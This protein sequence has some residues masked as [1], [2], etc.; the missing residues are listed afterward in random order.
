VYSNARVGLLCLLAPHMDWPEMVL[1]RSDELLVQAR[2]G[3]R[4][5]SFTVLD[6]GDVSRTHQEAQRQ[7]ADLV[8]RGAEVLVLYISGWVYGSTVVAAAQAAGVPVVL[9]TNAQKGTGGLIGAGVARGSLDEVGIEAP[10]VYGNFEDVR[11][12]HELRVHCLGRAAAQRLR[13]QTFGLMGGRTYGMYTAAIDPSHWRKRFGIEVENFDQLEVIERARAIPEGEARRYLAWVKSEF[14]GVH[15]ADEVMLRQ[16]RLYLAMKQVIA[17]LGLDFATVR[18]L[19]ET[20]SVY[21]TF[22][23][24]HALLNDTS[25]ADGLKA[26]FVCACENDANAALT[27]QLMKH[28]SGETACF[29]DMRHLDMATR[30]LTIANCGSQPTDLAA[31]RR[32]VHWMPDAFG[33]RHFQVGGACAQYVCKPGQ[34]TLGRLSRIDGQYVMLLARGEALERG[35]E[36]LE[37]GTSFSCTAQA[38]VRLDADPG[39]FIENV[40]S[41]HIH[42][43]YGDYVAA[44]EE[45]CRALRIPPIVEGG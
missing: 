33:E 3:L 32:E 30:I 4:A 41:N 24:A 40:R 21:T 34:V 42:M 27:M 1:R 43:V 37:D 22:C 29:S 17:E 12:M 31:S 5:L 45:A 15:V 2:E 16:V 14:G 11:A 9:W 19:P 44:L 10:L 39:F 13:G 20:P 25:D 35:R 26:P 23:F 18:C 36:A 28:V 7:A 6:T 8:T 38:V